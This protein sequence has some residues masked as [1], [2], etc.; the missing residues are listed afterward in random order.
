MRFV[1][2]ISGAS[3]SIYGIRLLEQLPGEKI[4][5][6]SKTAKKILEYETG[7]NFNEI[8]SMADQVFEDDDL[9]ASVASGSYFCDAMVIVPCSMSTMAK[10]A[11]G[12][13][14]TLITRTASVTLKEGRKLVMVPRETPKSAIMLENEMKLVRNGAIVLDAN[15]GFYTKP[16]K[17]DDMINFVVGKIM[18]QLDVEHN[19]YE[20]WK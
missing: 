18:D 12:I 7:R 2:A 19:L 13:A 17:I 8:Y 15:P 10:V 1:I 14:D 20:R 6:I 16:Q 9:F 5:V 4:L 3:G 11:T